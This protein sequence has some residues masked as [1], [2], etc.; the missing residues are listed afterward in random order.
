[1]V[2]PFIGAQARGGAAHGCSQIIRFALASSLV[3]PAAFGVA[4]AFMGF[5]YGAAQAIA[6]VT[7]PPLT[8]MGVMVLQGFLWRALCASLLVL[9]AAWSPIVSEVYL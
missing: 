2:I 1:M 4:S 5:P 3:F 6:S 9:V 7:R 8:C